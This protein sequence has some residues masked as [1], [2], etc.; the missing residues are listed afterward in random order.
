MTN[1]SIA[2]VDY[3][4]GN[5]GSIA[6]MLSRTGVNAEIT[7]T[8]QAL[9]DAHGII[10]PGV[11]AFDTGV[12]NLHE[13]GLWTL[14]KDLAKT[15]PTLGIC[16]GMQ[17]LFEKSEEGK[18][19]GLGLIPGEIL[20]LKPRDSSLKVPRMGWWDTKPQKSSQL[21]KYYEPDSRFYHVHSYHAVPSSPGAILLS[22][23]FEQ[24][25][26]SAVEQGH[27]FGVQFHPE[28]SHKYGLAL[29]R[30]FVDLLH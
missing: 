3:G 19:E 29:L 28:K 27:I 9:E 13:R 16:L 8:P 11:G 25:V 15:K 7:A 26:A 22:S 12:R 18:R 5:L 2:I 1:K 20:R 23:Q 17:L 30:G 24:T 14:L 21:L 10:L 4:L 6:N